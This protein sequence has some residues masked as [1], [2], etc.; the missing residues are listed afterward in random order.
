ML[1]SLEI[2]FLAFILMLIYIGAIS[3][4]FLFIIM[5]LKLNKEEIH[6]NLYFALSSKYYIYILIL[7][8]IILFL[9]HFNKKLSLSLD[10]FSYEFLK[11]NDDLNIFS[12]KLFQIEN[13]ILIFFNIFTQKYLFFLIVGFILL[14]SMIGSISLCLKKKSLSNVN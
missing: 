3:I 10:N 11:Y 1:F 7:L 5:M 13:D 9:F 6:K 8:K 2:E 14:F 12:T 4:L